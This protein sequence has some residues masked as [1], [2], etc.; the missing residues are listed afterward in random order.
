MKSRFVVIGIVLCA[1][2]LAVIGYVRFVAPGIEPGQ[3]TGNAAAEYYTCPMHP[4]VR[5]DR[6]GACP[7]C[8][9]ALVKKS[10][11]VQ[12]G[13]A[14]TAAVS[15]VTLSPTQRVI[16][17]I[18]TAAAQRRTLTRELHAVGVV[19][20]AEPLQATIAAR[21]RGRI[22]KLH[23]NFT[24]QRVRRG[25][26]LFDLYSPDLISAEREFLLGLEAAGSNASGDSLQT[27]LLRSTRERL[28][29]HF[30]LTEGQI[31]AI[32][33]DRR[34]QH[35]VSFHS[36]LSGTVL[37][38]GFQE[39]DFIDEGM[40]LYKLADLSRV[41]VILEIY[42]QDIRFIRKGM[43]VSVS[44]DAYPG[45]LFQGH[46]TFIDP[47]LNPE[48]RTVRVRVESTNPFG[49]LKPNMYVR[50][51]VRIT[52]PDA[53]VVPTTA[54]LVTGRRSVVWVEIRTNVFEP[55]TVTTGTEGDSFTQILSGLQA[56][57]SVA[58]T[59]GFLIDSESALSSPSAV[60]EAPQVHALA[61]PATTNDIE[62]IVDGRYVPDVVHVRAGQPVRLRFTRKEDSRCTDEVVFATLG[63]R[64][65]LP[66]WQ[67]TTIE[68]T[69]AGEG[70][71]PFE[72]G[73][74]MVHG[75]VLVGR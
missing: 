46:V 22:E 27:Q 41:W 68:F 21:F 14:D 7:V 57:E 64:R 35:T 49:K 6:P 50:G 52:V 65:S 71:I 18:S 59:G 15:G 37:E 26:P 73:M 16:A 67:T 23:V 66:A 48:S 58:V 61:Q 54:L 32:E 69:P 4:T 17:N 70:E 19:T 45:E 3:A 25:E 39:G 51:A 47:V 33:R 30:G 28:K 38:K 34:P 42:E 2:V 13:T 36:P 60:P 40:V 31:A 53:V 43:P 63:I 29:V 55:R 72:C 62:I 56:G 11:L 10:S 12:G 20:F 1:V 44:T 5:S 24:G 8:G 75:R 74:G 9:M